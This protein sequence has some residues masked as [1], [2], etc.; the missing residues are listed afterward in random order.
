MVSDAYKTSLAIVCPS[1]LVMSEMK[2]AFKYRQTA[3][4]LLSLIPL[5]DGRAC[6]TIDESYYCCSCRYNVGSIAVVLIHNKYSNVTEGQHFGIIPLMVAKL[7]VKMFSC[8][9]MWR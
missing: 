8:T 4:I 9:P 3:L 6:L 1:E 2:N 5:Y 7:Y